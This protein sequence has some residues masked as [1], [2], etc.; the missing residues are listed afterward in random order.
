M[1][2]RALRASRRRCR[3]TPRRK[4]N[5]PPG[6]CRRARRRRHRAPPGYSAYT[7]RSDGTESNP[8]ACTMR[9]PV[10]AACFV[11]GVDAVPDEHRLS[12]QVGV[13]GAGGRTRGHQRQPVAGVRADRS[14]D[15]LGAGRHLVEGGGRAGVGLQDRP[16]LRGVAERVADGTQLLGG[17]AGQRNPLVR[18][19]PGQV[20]GGELADEAGSPIQHNVEFARCCGRRPDATPASQEVPGARPGTSWLAGISRG[21]RTPAT[22]RCPAS[23][24]RSR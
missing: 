18:C 22:R 14:D 21:G 12:G 13:V 5:A 16:G 9:A 7:L 17:P 2:C 10:S 1:R 6:R 24:A 3:R 20:L 8:Q 19:R 11:I 15:D 23:A 4:R